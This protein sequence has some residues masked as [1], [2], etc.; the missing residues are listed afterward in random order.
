MIPPLAQ[1]DARRRHSEAGGGIWGRGLSAGVEG[2]LGQGGHGIRLSAAEA[3][4]LPRGCSSG[5]TRGDPPTGILCP[6]GSSAP[7]LMGRGTGTP[8]RP[9]TPWCSV[10]SRHGT[11][12][13]WLR[14]RARQESTSSCVPGRVP[15][16]GAGF[17]DFLCGSAEPASAC[18]E[19]FGDGTS[20][21]LTETGSIKQ[22]FKS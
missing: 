2:P 17:L 7:R 8:H 11:N 16:R 12:L 10:P 13:H 4:A 18:L 21:F 14:P 3:K 1:N 9:R 19:L 15:L 5:H 20:A 22:F 6:L